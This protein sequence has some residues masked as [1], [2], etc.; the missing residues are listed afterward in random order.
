MESPKTC[1]ELLQR[2][3]ELGIAYSLHHHPATPTVKEGMKFRQSIPGV[4]CKNLFLRDAKKRYW[5][6]TA[7]IEREIQLKELPAVIGS[8]RL[9]FA[10][11]PR[12]MEK[13][14]VTPGSVTPFAL[15]ND[16]D[17]SVSVILDDWMMRQPVLHVHPLVNTATIGVAPQDL[18][19]FIHACGHSPCM[20]DLQ[21]LDIQLADELSA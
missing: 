19:R 2:L 13:L 8:A 1:D 6:V 14:G 20:V 12:L 9:S 7:P 10:Q 5:L 16:Q 4:H 21:A 15:I 18:L 17:T 3:D 11:P